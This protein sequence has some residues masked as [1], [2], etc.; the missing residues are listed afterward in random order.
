MKRSLA[1]SLSP[2]HLSGL[3]QLSGSRSTD[4]R[5]IIFSH[6]CRFV[7]IALHINCNNGWCNRLCVIQWPTRIKKTQFYTQLNSI[8][9]RRAPLIKVFI[10][11]IHHT[12]FDQFYSFIFLFALLLLLVVD[13][14]IG[15]DN[16]S[17]IPTFTSS[18]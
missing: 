14:F 4:L 5:R 13:I 18:T 11:H 7:Q 17:F 2:I 8:C 1:K 6:C 15:R 10:H 12:V 3:L 16:F 9:L